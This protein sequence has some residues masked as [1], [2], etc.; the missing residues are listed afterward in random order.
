MGAHVRGPPSRLKCPDESALFGCRL[1]ACR[2]IA[3]CV[4]RLPV[5]GCR[6]PA[7]EPSAPSASVACRLLDI[8]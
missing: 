4:I 6:L 2:L 7:E 1:P 8:S 5:A 3:I